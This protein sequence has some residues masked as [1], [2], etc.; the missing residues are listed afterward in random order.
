MSAVRTARFTGRGYDHAKAA[1]TDALATQLAPTWTLM[2]RAVELLRG[3]PPGGH[4]AARWDADKAA[5]TWH[6][7]H[8]RDG[9][10]RSRAATGRS[11]PPAAW[12]TRSY[13]ASERESRA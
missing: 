7:Q 4:V 1:L 8:L 3:L 9:G 10:R 13:G 11:P 2:W 5:F 6:A 12:L